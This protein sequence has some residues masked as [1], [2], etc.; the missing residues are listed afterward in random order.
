MHSTALR[1]RWPLALALTFLAA[2]ADEPVGVSTLATSVPSRPNAF[3]EHD[4]WVTVTT[5]SG[6]ALSVREIDGQLVALDATDPLASR[7][8][9]N[10][11]VNSRKSIAAKQPAPWY[12]R[13]D[14]R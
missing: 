6:E 12:R 3:A 1:G 5:T 4:A 2:C 7:L 13:F 10:R 8:R 14:K 9:Q 11:K